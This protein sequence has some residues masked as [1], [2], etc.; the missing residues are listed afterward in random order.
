MDMSKILLGH[1]RAVADWV[2]ARAKG[3]AFHDPF[4]A[5]GLLDD[6]GHLQGGFVFTG[7]NGDC[8]ELSLAGR[9]VANRGAM[10]MVVEYVFGQLGCSRLQMHTRESNKLVLRMLSKGKRGNGL[11]FTFEGI[12]RR[13]YGRENGVLYSLTIDDLPKFR[14]RWGLSA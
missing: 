3:K 2:A 1:D 7:Y 8:V 9:A 5:I 12:S 13:F 6:V 11:N 10:G 14:Q 4:T